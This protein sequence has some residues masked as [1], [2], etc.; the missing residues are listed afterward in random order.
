MPFDLEMPDIDGRHAAEAP[1]DVVRDED[2]VGL[3]HT[4]LVL[5]ER[6]VA[7]DLVAIGGRDEL[8][9]LGRLRAPF[10]KVAERSL[11]LCGRGCG[12]V[13]PL[14]RTHGRLVVLSH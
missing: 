2:R 8:L 7:R 1:H 5:Y 12:R 13:L 3:V 6:E 11:D 9:A 14:C 4:R 10:R